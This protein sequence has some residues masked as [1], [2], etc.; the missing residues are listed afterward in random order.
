MRAT[1]LFLLIVLGCGSGIN[2][3]STWENKLTQERLRVTGSGACEDLQTR[4]LGQ[5]VPGGDTDDC[6]SY[7]V[8]LDGGGYMNVVLS[9]ESFLEHNTR[10]LD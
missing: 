6:V 5:L 10:V 8:R 2:E 3:G 7:E 1:P 9:M 4:G